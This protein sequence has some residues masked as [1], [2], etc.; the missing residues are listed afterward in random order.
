MNLTEEQIY[1]QVADN[2]ITMEEAV[3]LLERLNQ[4]P[5]GTVD[6][7]PATAQHESYGNIH[8][9]AEYP[10][11]EGQRTF[12]II[13][14]LA[15]STYAYNIPTA[16]HVAADIDLKVL[17]RA[18][19]ELARRHG[20]LRAV[21]D[22][23]D[24]A[25]YQHVQPDWDAHVDVVDLTGL[26]DAA[27]ATRMLSEAQR[28]FDLRR[29]PVMRATLFRRNSGDH[30][31]LLCTH[32][33]VFDGISLGIFM[34]ELEVIYQAYRR[35]QSPNL[36]HLDT[37]YRDFVFWQR[38]MLASDS[39]HAMR[40][41]WL[42]ELAGDWQLPQWPLDHPRPSVPNFIGKSLRV[43]MDQVTASRYRDTAKAQRTSLYSLMLAAF[44]ETQRRYTGSHDLFIGTPV[45]GRPQ[46]R[47]ERII[48]YFM[49]M[50]VLRASIQ[51]T[52]T[53]SQ[54]LNHVQDKLFGGLEN[55]DYPLLTLTE[56]L[57]EQGVRRTQLFNTAFY[58]QNWLKGQ[59]RDETGSG[60]LRQQQPDIHQEGEFDITLEVYE[61][62]QTLRLFF[63]YNPALFDAATIDHLAKFYEHVLDHMCRDT[64]QALRTIPSLAAA[65]RQQLLVNWN[66]TERKL[67]SQRATQQLI[68]ARVA[69]TPENLAVESD[70][71]RLT[72]AQLNTAA[73]RL[74][75][76]LRA[77][78]VR[79]GAYVG[80][81]LDRDAKLPATL[82]AIF[83]A[84]A[85]YIPLDPAFPKD[86]LAY[87]AQDSGLTHLIT[88]SAYADRLATPSKGATLL[89][90]AWQGFVAEPLSQDPFPAGA[91]DPDHDAYIIYTS[92]S[93]GK[94]KGVAVGH[95]ALTNFLT[96]MAETPG[97]AP[98]D[99]LLAV[100][101]VSFDIAGLELFLP[102]TRGGVV[103]VVSAEVAKNGLQLKT[104]VETSRPTV[105]QATPAT[106]QMLIA[107]EWQGHRP[108]KI[109]AGG[110]ALSRDLADALTARCDSLWNMFGPT[111]T[112]IWST[113]AEIRPNEPITVGRPIA[114]TR[115]YVLD[116]NLQPVPVGAH[117]E[118]FIG[119]MGLANRYHNRVEL[120]AER[121]VDD[122]FD[123]RSG[124]RM[125]RTGDLVRYRADGRLEYLNRMDQQIKLR[126]YRIELGEIEGALRKLS[127]VEEAAAVVR[128][129]HTGAK[130]LVAF[131]QV[132]QARDLDNAWRETLLKW[133]PE[134]MV[135]NRLIAVKHFPETLNRKLDR[136]TLT[137]MPMADIASNYGFGEAAA[138][139]ADLSSDSPPALPEAAVTARLG[140]N[141]QGL[142]KDLQHMAAEILD[143][144][145]R[146]L[147]ASAPLGTF[148]F[149]SLRFTSLAVAL[150][151]K[152][153]ID[154]QPTL[155]YEHN[156]LDGIASRLYQDF[157]ELI[158]ARYPSG[159]AQPQ[160]A[161]QA[162]QPA[163]RPAAQ[164]N[165]PIEP[166]EPIAIVG[167]AGMFPGSP[168]LDTFWDNLVA[169][170]DLV[171][172][173][174]SDR[175]RWQD[176][177]PNGPEERRQAARWGAFVP[178][179]DKFDSLFFGISPAE[180]QSMDPQ[181][182][183]F[184]QVVW[185]CVE[186][187]GYRADHL[188]G[189]D[190][191]LFVGVANSDYKDLFQAVGA[192]AEA[193]TS[194]G[195][196]HA[197]LANRVSFA[198]DW[199]G[200]SEPI[201]AACASSTLA[202]HNACNAIRGGD[203]AM[204]I[205]GG[206][207]LLLTPGGH[208]ALAM[209][210]M[211]ASDGK[212]RPFAKG[213]NGYVRGE[214]A[215]AV[216][217]KPLRQA[218]ADGDH[219]YGVVMGSAVNHGGHTNSLTSPNPNAQ[220]RLLIRAFKR[221]GVDPSQVNYIEASAN[222]TEL[223]DPLEITALK[224][225]YANL[226]Q[227]QGKPLPKDPMCTIG[228][229]K[230]NIGHL[231]TAAGI[232]G[233]IKVLLA[234]KHGQ[235]PGN[236]HL[237]ETNPYLPLA[238][239]PF[240][241]L[242][243]N[244]PW[245]PTR[246]GDPLYAGV[247]SFGYGGINTHVLLRSYQT[248]ERGA[249][250]TGPQVFPL[251]AKNAQRLEVYATKL[252]DWLE[253][254]MATHD[255]P[256]LQ[257]IAFTLQTG[258]NAMR[259]R[260]AVVADSSS[261]LLDGLRHYLA[262]D[263]HDAVFTGNVRRQSDLADLLA[264]EDGEM[265]IRAAMEKRACSKLARFWVT[266]A[267][268]DW[269]ALHTTSPRR[270]A[271]PTY[272]FEPVRH[273]L[274]LD[275]A[276]IAD[277]V[278]HSTA[279][280]ETASPAVK[281]SAAAA[282]TPPAKQPTQDSAKS[283][284]A[285]AIAYLR[286]QVAEILKLPLEQIDPQED[287]A[288]YGFDSFTSAKLADL[289]EE[290]QGI[291][292]TSRTFF[293]Y[294]TLADLA[295]YLVDAHELKLTQPADDTRPKSPEAAPVTAAVNQPVSAENRLRHLRHALITIVETML[296]LPAGTVD[297]GEDLA[298]Y[299]FDSF[300]AARFVNYLEDEAEIKVTPRQLADYLSAE[301]LAG[302]LAAKPGA[303]RLLKAV[304]PQADDS[305]EDRSRTT[306]EQAPPV[307]T[308]VAPV[309]TKPQA[310]VAQEE[311]VAKSV[312][313][314]TPQS[315]ETNTVSPG[316]TAAVPRESHV[317]APSYSG[318]VEDSAT[319]A[320]RYPLSESQKAL[321]FIQQ[322]TPENYGYNLPS[323][324]LLHGEQDV[325]AW[326][327]AL[328]RL[329]DRHPM[330]RTTFAVEG[331]HT[332]QVVHPSRKAHFKV[333]DVSNIPW[334]EAIAQIQKDAFTP[335]DL[336]QGPLYRVFLYS[337]SRTDHVILSVMHHIIFD[338]SSSVILMSD[339]NQFLT[340]ETEG[341]PA[342]LPA[343]KASYMDFVQWQQ[344]YLGGDAGQRA[345]EYWQ[346]RLAG[347][348]PVLNLPLDYPR[349]ANQTFNG[350]VLTVD[351]PISVM[352][353]L[354][355]AARQKRA[356]MFTLLTAAYLTLLYRYTQQLDIVVGTPVSG[357]PGSRFEQVIGYFV[358]MIAIRGDFTNNLPFDDYLAQMQDQIFDAIEHGD[359]PFPVLLNRLGIEQEKNQTPVY[360][361]VFIYQNW[362]QSLDPSLKKSTT[363][364]DDAQ[365]EEDL[366]AVHE[367]GGFDLTLEIYDLPDK[368]VAY[369][370][371]NRDLF[372]ESRIRR[373]AGHFKI[374][375][376]SILREPQQR[377]GRLN[378]LPDAE[379]QL[380]IRG[381]N[382]NRAPV[383]PKTVHRLFEEE[384]Q[385]YPER[386]AVLWED[387][388]D[389]G[390]RNSGVE[391]I[392]YAALNDR[393][394]QLAHYLRQRGIGPEV[395][396][397]L[398]MP[399]GIDLFVCL[400]GI[401]KTGGAYIPIDHEY[402]KDRIANMLED[403][404]PELV[405]TQT[406]LENVLPETAADIVRFDHIQAELDQQ[407]SNN[408]D[409]AM[410]TGNLIYAIFTSG[411]TG[412]PK[413]VMIS[414]HA[415]VNIFK[416]WEKSYQIREA[417]T[418]HMLMANVSFDVFVGDMTRSLLTGKRC[419]LCPR[420]LLLIPKLL[421][422]YMRNHGADVAEFVPAVLR[423]LTDHVEEI[424]ANYHFLKMLIAGSDAWTQKEYDR[425][426]S[427]C[428]PKTRLINSYGVTET[429]I[430]A[431]WWESEE[432]A[433]NGLLETAAT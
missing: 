3:R 255:L 146:E 108:L 381:F 179:V 52:M 35:H 266:G 135:P 69:Q 91:I 279:T 117:G 315:G 95:R 111:E 406:D 26:G 428:G 262:G 145:A 73:N 213:A 186:D 275:P 223:G 319:Q 422:D 37:T 333:R 250:D 288:E 82:L 44:F 398:C 226:Y 183:L 313:V 18:L 97:F 367:T 142:L 87:M 63:K 126:G 78:G 210:G 284:E 29:G 395:M 325:D 88:Q 130:V 61:Y 169:G 212:S 404:D 271:L 125:Y 189:S 380:L 211:I 402:P 180:A 220:T 329:V 94:P 17:R 231:E 144:P 249:T 28:P 31:L 294:L 22:E 368:A 207:N 187:A 173:I 5:D 148:G 308:P 317:S 70:G 120:T 203:C 237:N 90:Q 115:I 105:I 12:W 349:P 309:Q 107:A 7:S 351:L 274:D 202:I 74:A 193:H 92:G 224:N 366:E 343:S 272:P 417:T 361:S 408:P 362:L 199:H 242:T 384:V 433:E 59:R 311:Q 267:E 84:G 72:Y 432:S 225:A 401:M 165:T 352:K 128:T 103:D 302:F 127:T 427:F 415:V 364:A 205:A 42:N 353:G 386:V 34:Q 305:I 163:P 143:M 139:T 33:I 227:E 43:D 365:T 11:S 261:T 56:A 276:R 253:R 154:V 138:A 188:A 83:K 268:L 147:Q 198:M 282:N 197:I 246:A 300:S 334:S 119:G 131:A 383:P 373:M 112:T 420:N 324:G 13:H 332:V 98:A 235:Q 67:D 178:D 190:T 232:A 414:H 216:L 316:E 382:Q 403:S 161:V 174:P 89:D 62:Q 280:A 299:G 234:M 27:S 214:G 287:M 201:N 68:E 281:L 8:A 330:L 170:R 36:P 221:A 273:W 310:A 241:L 240:R 239:S 292:L 32:H 304:P 419:L 389:D 141:H 278:G 385:K 191:G 323:T 46:S 39:G 412:R 259:E 392:T 405:L 152:F 76:H 399:R 375:L 185:S 394:N 269:S 238:D 137:Q 222:G 168:D 101:T 200:P 166:G 256:P 181:Q 196:S 429:T 155:F 418:A 421:F 132:R 64:S 60:L 372:K 425:F 283:A 38:D 270:I 47:F 65:A 356:S 348:L 124:A 79:P 314:P 390:T 236:I 93:T 254:G 151:K 118:L 342:N 184:M 106:W 150:N 57:G 298:E 257:D 290:E 113:V 346:N 102:L 40:D 209:A 335:F 1:Q 100:T 15:P 133:L 355:R 16:I 423:V 430:D 391:Q 307:Q 176:F 295:N 219:I 230:A 53:I 252:R 215:G 297:P 360:Q 149:D 248:P 136:K 337:R 371:Y 344:D 54:L 260:L 85:A 410:S 77:Q 286:R 370:K 312:S 289:L 75:A 277:I 228:S 175:W 293:D 10:L 156:T 96:S 296:K 347:E 206:V 306:Q 24:G 388:A 341:T 359:F 431:T 81:M 104:R 374:L 258:R 50:V 413:G 158:T 14:R 243:K 121:F 218:E 114:N 162:Q 251:S 159:T 71:M 58:F 217:L 407:P 122:P 4:R 229:V 41:Y 116:G 354:K 393:A 357:R 49:N 327:R 326:Q 134:Y 21:F 140:Y 194:T 409:I 25:P 195:F 320:G 363:D 338:G 45:A 9:Q 80:V 340:E 424:G 164:A 30:S 192:D 387:V 244:Q 6:Q 321:W 109:L 328:N 20:S 345:W 291:S 48:G 157:S 123:S 358:N 153:G 376:E 99:R 245:R 396:V 23:R 172:E 322:M 182:R 350:T 204:A 378:I 2:Q 86:R 110:E 177:Q 339:L 265:F 66:A 369:F 379:R 301:E 377:L 264:G 233:V 426:F 51:D 167:M 397:G 416:A 19:G 247:S 336:E 208:I 318:I 171:S 285:A 400:F 263:A 303:D 160:A 129:D 411:S 55:G 331:D